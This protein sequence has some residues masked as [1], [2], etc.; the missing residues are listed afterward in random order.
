MISLATLLA[1]LCAVVAFGAL[2]DGR[3]LALDLFGP[4]IVRKRD[5]PRQIVKVLAC[6]VVALAAA[7]AWALLV[8]RLAVVQ[9]WAPRSFFY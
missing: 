4:G 2:H 3:I 7:S 9:S 5:R 1:L 6:G 8:L